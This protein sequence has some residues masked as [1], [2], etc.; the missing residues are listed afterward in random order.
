MFIDAV[1]EEDEYTILHQW[2]KIGKAWPLIWLLDDDQKKDLLAVKA[3]IF[4]ELIMTSDLYGNNPLHIAASTN[5]DDTTFVEK[6]I[7]GY[8]EENLC[9]GE[10][11]E[12]LDRTPWKEKN[13]YG[14]LCMRHYLQ[15]RKKLRYICYQSIQLYVRLITI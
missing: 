6:L 10:M 13:D 2:A 11:F 5:E 9:V 4:G 8:K 3:K 1:T 12:S 15:N 14:N 7:H